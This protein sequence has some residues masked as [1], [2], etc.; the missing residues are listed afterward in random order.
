MI[1][2]RLS[3]KAQTTVPQPVRVA[4]SLNEGDEIGYVIE[5]DRVYITRVTHEPAEDPFGTF[6]EW[7]SEADRRAYG[8]L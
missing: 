2:S 8:S 7:A 1:T 4:L 5:A 6:G 3:S